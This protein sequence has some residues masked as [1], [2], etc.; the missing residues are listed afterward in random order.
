MEE[1]K[2][3]IYV[4]QGIAI[5]GSLVRCVLIIVDHLHDD[6]MTIRNKKLRNVLIALLLIETCIGLGII[7]NSYYGGDT[8]G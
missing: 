3:L 6:D 2:S 4:I 8:D 7:I 1:I 5:G